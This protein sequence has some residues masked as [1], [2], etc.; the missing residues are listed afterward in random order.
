MAR[1]LF[2]FLVL[3]LPACADPPPPELLGTWE[4]ANGH[5]GSATFF[6]DGRV[7]ID[8]EQP[9]E[10]D[11]AWGVYRV[12][13]ETVVIEIGAEPTP[14]TLRDGQLVQEDGTVYRRRAD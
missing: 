3:A 4:Q 13:G 1:F 10:V 5:R 14:L 12:A 2:A 11:T 8:L 9:D 7:F 6:E